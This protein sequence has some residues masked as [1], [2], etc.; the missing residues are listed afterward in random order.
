MREVSL[1]RRSVTC[2]LE[3]R[4]VNLR[5]VD[6]LSIVVGKVIPSSHEDESHITQRP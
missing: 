1:Q 2:L 5:D 4:D 3:V 6:C